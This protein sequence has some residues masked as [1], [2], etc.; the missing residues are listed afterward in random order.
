PRNRTASVCSQALGRAS[1]LL[2]A[3]SPLDRGQSAKLVGALYMVR[4]RS[5]NDRERE[6]EHS[7]ESRCG[8][9]GS[10]DFGARRTTDQCTGISGAF[11]YSPGTSVEERA[12]ALFDGLALSFTERYSGLVR[13]ACQTGKPSRS[14]KCPNWRRDGM[15]CTC[16]ATGTNG[17]FRKRARFLRKSGLHQ[18]FGRWKSRTDGSRI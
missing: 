5:C 13:P 17:A 6:G 14:C 8:A 3:N 12:R 18:I 2:D 10:D 11:R 7:H 15:G 1:L 16:H 4:L 9:R